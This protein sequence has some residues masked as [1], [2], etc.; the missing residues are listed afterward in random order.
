MINNSVSFNKNQRY[1]GLDIVRSVAMLLG[2]VIHVSIF[3]MDGQAF[4]MRGEHV[5]DPFNEMIVEF[6]HLFRMQL[7]FLLAGFFAQM[8]IE[9]KGLSLFLKDRIKR[10]LIPFIFA[11]I[12]LVPLMEIV[13]SAS[14]QP[15]NL[16][17]MLMDQ[18][19]MECV[20]SSVLYGLFS[21]QYHRGFIGFWHYWFI[22]FMLLMYTAHVALRW[23]LPSSFLSILGDWLRSI[24]QKPLAAIWLGLLCFPIHYSLSSPSFPP[25]HLNFDWNN[26]GYYLVFYF[27]GVGLYRSPEIIESLQKSCF[28]NL[29]LGIILV[30]FT[31]LLTPLVDVNSSA[32]HDLLNLQVVGFHWVTEAILEGGVLKAAVVLMRACAIWLFSLG[33]IGLAERFI[34]KSNPAVKY[35]S[36][37]SYWIFYVHLILTFSLSLFLA[38]LDIINSLTKAYI[39]IVASFY[40]LWWSYNAFVRYTFL[41]DYFMGQ[42][43][44]RGQ[45]E[46][47]DHIST[48]SVLKYTWR[49]VLFGLFAA[50]VVGAALREHGLIQ[51]KQY[52][53]E[54]SLAQVPTVFDAVGKIDYVTDS[55]G[56]T[57][58]HLA[59]DLRKDV[60]DYNPVAKLIPH[61]THVN[62]L[63][64]MQRTPLFN[65]ARVGNIEDVRLLLAAGADPNLADK[66][67]HTPAHVAAIKVGLKNNT[68][69]DNYFKLLTVLRENGANMSSKDSK[70]R[71][72]NDCLKSFGG[73]VIK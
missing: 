65:A 24:A 58:L 8:V 23:L 6:I 28:I 15:S 17:R 20:K 46:D 63:D 69:S 1:Y 44:V 27:F 13:V 36:E 62:P 57:A 33:F 56:R 72:V 16:R 51:G 52:L 2:L 26:L 40:I 9:R 64:N 37:S 42:R 61:F 71:D 29:S 35:L 66:Y 30:P 11:V 43:K 45:S 31:M 4:W 59:A 70:G 5:T 32:V 10:I 34:R 22:Y 48:L 47:D 21:E 53:N 19:F 54:A 3:F 14:G 73:R 60:R 50:Y 38:K 39:I 12:F 55:Y 49:P 25:N 41:G 7:F 68:I 18:S 67:G